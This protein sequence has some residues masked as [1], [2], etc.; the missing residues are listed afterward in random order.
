M[1]WQSHL[2]CR[3]LDCDCESLTEVK[4]N[5]PMRTW[6]KLIV[7]GDLES[8]W[9]VL[10]IWLVPNAMSKETHIDPFVIIEVGL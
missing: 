1:K 6:D 5:S 7:L 2:T 3:I 10:P 4:I 9:R 8:S